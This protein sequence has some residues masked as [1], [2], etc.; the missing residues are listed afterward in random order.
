MN[1][2]PERL[3][4]L[5]DLVETY[6]TAIA[7]KEIAAFL[8]ECAK[9]APVYQYLDSNGL[10]HEATKDKF[11]RTSGNKQ[12]LYTA[13][14]VAV[15]KVPDEKKP[16]TDVRSVEFYTGHMSGWNDCRAEVLRLNEV[17]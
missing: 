8:R 9:C 1:M 17:K 7:A 10:W 2:T 12:I 6:S 5:A 4:E 3:R 11:E 13:P 14:S 15:V 16:D